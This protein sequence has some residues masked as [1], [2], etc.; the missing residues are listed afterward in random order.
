MYR[1]VVIAISIH[2]YVLPGMAATC[3]CREVKLE[4][5]I[6]MIVVVGV[7]WLYPDHVPAAICGK[8]RLPQI[9]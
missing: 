6:Q 2:R 3:F 5:T 9:K 8:L 4:K 1:N 7:V